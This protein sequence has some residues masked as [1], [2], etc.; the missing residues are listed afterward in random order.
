MNIKL[1]VAYHKKAPLVQDPLFVPIHLGHGP[2]YDWLDAHMLGDDTGDNISDRN[3]T[4]NELT[5][6]YWAW[7]H[8][9]QLGNPDKI[10]FCHYRRF[11]IFDRRKA[12]YFEGEETGIEAQ[13]YADRAAAMVQN[14]DFVAPIP[15]K[16]RSVYQNYKDA[17]HKEDI[18]LTLKIIAD[19]YP[20]MW[21]AAKTYTAGQK[22]FFYN[23]FVMGREDFGA[24]CRFVFDV[25][26]IYRQQTTHPDERY[27][28]S[29][30][31]TGIFFT[32]M[33]Q[34]GKSV[35]YLPVLFVDKP[36]TL[37]Q[38]IAETKSNLKQK[39]TGTLYAFRP[40]LIRLIPKKCKLRRKQKSALTKEERNA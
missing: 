23:M 27:F 38:A 22:V 39:K 4:Y 32:F 13:I 29:E 16:R 2:D 28:I 11:F 6:I 9:D 36:Q 25:L 12:A 21:G 19:N 1:L 31:L 33:L 26:D 8:Y 7:K 14:Y 30:V 10:G 15:N 40:L 20:A 3:P 18:D 35:L 17:H 37:G 5:A 24:Y 34:Q